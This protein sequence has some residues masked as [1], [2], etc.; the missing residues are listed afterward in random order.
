MYPLLLII[1]FIAEVTC[2]GFWVPAYFRYGVPIFRMR[3]GDAAPVAAGA[4]VGLQQR[5]NDAPRLAFKM[6]DETSVAIRDSWASLS[7]YTPVMHGIIH[8]AADGNSAHITGYVNWTPMAILGVFALTPA[9][10]EARY[11]GVLLL[12]IFVVTYVIE[13]RRYAKLARFLLGER[14]AGG[15]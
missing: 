8:D 10:L 13:A 9:P 15:R 4:H 7:S 14:T 1:V 3:L 11:F 12:V 6:L 5:F 2:S